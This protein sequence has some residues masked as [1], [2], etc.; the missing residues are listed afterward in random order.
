MNLK[1]YKSI[2][3]LGIGGISMSALALILKRRGYNVSGYDAV[4]SDEVAALENAG[5]PVCTDVDEINLS[6]FE[7]VVFTAALHETHPAMVKAAKAGLPIFSRASLLGAIAAGYSHSTG[8]A[9]THGKST[10]SGM[11]SRIYE[12]DGDSTYI[13]GAVLPF[14][15]SAYKLGH[16]DRIVFEACEYRDSFLEFHPSL[17]V[18]L[19]VRLDHTDYFSDE[20]AIISSF[21]KYISGSGSALINAD[22]RNAIIA[23][24]DTGVSTCTFSVNGS[25]D[26]TA[27]YDKQAGAFPEFDILE[28]GVKTAHIKL[29]IP[30]L[31]NVYNAVAAFA[32]ARLTGVSADDA[33]KGLEGFH[34]VKRRFELCTGI[35]SKAKFYA[36]YAHHPDELKATLEAA[37]TITTGRVIAVFQPHTFSRLKSFFVDFAS[38]L[39]KADEV[40]VTNVYAAREKDDGTISGKMLA[41]AIPGSKY[42]SSFDDIASVLLSDAGEGDTVLILGAGDI[43]RL[44][45]ILKRK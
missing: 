8:V 11:L 12:E 14:V 40:I 26:F 9:G 43:I 6:G 41:E 35:D 27:V 31:H 5:I 18:V 36:D 1:A 21:R 17:A 45:D 20:A 28:N 4:R 15:D 19:N 39:S 22:D 3:F 25:A 2:Y 44:A 29:T 32:A 16:D 10:C 24:K 30:G 37:R 38:A 13:V 34:G 7:A 42:I 33:I 23:A